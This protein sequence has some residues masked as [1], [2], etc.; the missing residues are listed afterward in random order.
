[1]IKSRK[2]ELLLESDEARI[3]PKTVKF[4]FDP[5]KHQAV[6]TVFERPLKPVQCG[7]VVAQ[8]GV[9]NRE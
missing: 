3:R 9:N 7:L 4:R 8:S 5:Q 1:L 2:V 6:R